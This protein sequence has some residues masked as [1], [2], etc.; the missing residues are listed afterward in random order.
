MRSFRT[1]PRAPGERRVNPPLTTSACASI[2]LAA[3]ALLT[4]ACGHKPVM[5]A[6]PQP[7]PAM[8][9]GVSWGRPNAA[10]EYPH[11]ERAPENVQPEASERVPAPLRVGM[12]WQV[13]VASFYGRREQGN[14]TASGERFDMRR[15]TA[16]ARTLPFGTIV[17]VTDLATGRSVNVRINDRGPFWPHRIIDLS[18]GAAKR[19]GLYRQGLGRVRLRIVRLPRP[20]PPGVYTVQVGW[21][22]RRGEFQRC[23]RAMRRYLHEPVVSFHS[24][25]GRW[26]RY[27]RRV[28]LSRRTAARLV[29]ALRQDR[30][31]AYLVRLN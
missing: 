19:I 4:S 5:L 26:L 13:G 14:Y 25:E 10:G 28:R 22:T 16:A 30:Y 2:L 7:P 20:L 24:R 1:S 18:V 27:Q 15:M 21:F 6:P 23:R 31:P 17:R 11:P 12:I 3:L 8:P 9:P 29:A